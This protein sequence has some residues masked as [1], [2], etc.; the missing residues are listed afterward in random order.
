MWAKFVLVL[1][2]LFILSLAI[3]NSATHRTIQTGSTTNTTTFLSE[4]SST[5]FSSSTPLTTNLQNTTAAA[6]SKTDAETNSS[7]SSFSPTTFTS[8]VLPTASLIPS[9]QGNISL[10]A[11]TML[12]TSAPNIT[13]NSSVVVTGYSP[14]INSSSQSDNATSATYS[15][16]TNNTAQPTSLHTIDNSSFTSRKPT[17]RPNGTGHG[18]VTT[19]KVSTVTFTPDAFTTILSSSS[20]T[21]SPNTSLSPEKGTGKEDKIAAPSNTG[22]ALAVV[23][24]L[25]LIIVALLGLVMYLKKRR[26][27]YSRLQEDNTTGSWSNYNNPVFEDL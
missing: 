22:T 11:T 2:Q 20:L 9:S 25:I 26:V 12:P 3:D 21:P 5:A 15:P 4:N 24:S 16:L 1:C 10:N 13:S 8:T 18:E 23:I 6:S 19:V 27:F 7:L 17:S 14:N